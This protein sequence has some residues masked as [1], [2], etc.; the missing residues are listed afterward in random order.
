M[1]QMGSFAEYF[2]SSLGKHVSKG[3]SQRA[4]EGRH[5]GG[6]PFGYESCWKAKD[7]Q[8]IRACEPEHAGGVHR[9]EQ[10]AAA[11]AELF[12]RYSSG[13]TSTASLAAYLN[14]EGLRTRNTKSMPD[15]S[16]RAVAGPRLFTC[17]SV[18]VILRNPFYVG[19]VRYKGKLIAGRH[20][21]IVSQGL[22]D[23]VQSALTRNSGRSITLRRV[24]TRDYT[25]KGL[26]LCAWCSRPL[27][28]ETLNSGDAYYREKSASHGYGDCVSGSRSVRAETIDA[29]V[30]R[31]F[32]AIELCPDWRRRVLDRIN[33]Q[34]DVTLI[35]KERRRIEERLKR[36][37]RVYIDGGIAEQDYARDRQSLNSE[38]AGLVIP[39]MSAAV[40]AARLIGNLPRLWEKASVSER[41]SLA[42]S[43]FDSVYVDTRDSQSVVGIRPKAIFKPLF[44]AVTTAAGSGVVLFRA[45]DQPLVGVPGADDR[46]LW[47][48]RGRVELPVQKVLCATSTSVPGL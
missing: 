24:G 30:G 17:S 3:Q 35:N 23:T 4:E 7:S 22:F 39:E 2:S 46:W 47:W 34:D 11:V 18:R 37:G 20:D 15:W 26:V 38:L 10:E 43:L 42:A 28:A 41:H 36:L 5:L 9:N 32:S 1:Q 19:H 45:T 48:R 29:Q 6:I 16:G 21:P 13:T 44:E 40:E 27:W 12:M 31:L 8:R 25:L 14:L 33:A